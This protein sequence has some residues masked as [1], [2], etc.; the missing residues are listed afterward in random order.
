KKRPGSMW[1]QA[2][3]ASSRERP[4][5]ARVIPRA[6]AVFAVQIILRHVPVARGRG[7]SAAAAAFVS[8]LEALRVVP[9]LREIGIR[10][11]RRHVV[12]GRFRKLVR[13]CKSQEVKARIALRLDAVEDVASPRDLGG[14]RREVIGAEGLT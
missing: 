1:N 12:G 6:A 2:Q 11:R 7:Q 13:G 10:S 5:G 9:G 3:I 4:S 8:D 14:V